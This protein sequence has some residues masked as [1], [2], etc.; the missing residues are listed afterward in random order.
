MVGIAA[1]ALA[2]GSMYSLVTLTTESVILD[3]DCSGAEPEAAT[4]TQSAAGFDTSDLRQ[5]LPGLL[6]TASRSV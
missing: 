6:T 3:R 2:L 4:A 5:D 1:V